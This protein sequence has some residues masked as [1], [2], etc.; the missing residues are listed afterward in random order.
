M[1]IIH[2][3][4]VEGYLDNMRGYGKYYNLGPLILSPKISELFGPWKYSSHRMVIFISEKKCQFYQKENFSWLT[5]SFVLTW[6]K[7]STFH[8]PVYQNFN[9]VRKWLVDSHS[10]HPH[11]LLGRRWR[12]GAEP[13]ASHQIFKTGRLGGILI[14]RGGCCERGSDFFQRRVAVFTIK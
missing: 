4:I 14:F 10:V 13:W 12:E 9:D 6:K 8:E 7:A 2:F 1:D 11:L 5:V 3:C